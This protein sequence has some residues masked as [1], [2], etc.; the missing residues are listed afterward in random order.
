MK[1]KL[2][3]ASDNYYPRSDGIARFLSEIIPRLKDTYDITIVCPAYKNTVSGVHDGVNV[4]RIPL[5]KF[6]V[7]DFRPA[8]FEKKTIRE[9]VKQADIVF[10]Q[11]IGPVGGLALLAAHRQKK[12]LVSFIHSV[13]WDLVPMAIK[14][15]FLRRVA[16]PIVRRMSR[17]FYSKCDLIIVPSHNILD[18]VSW[19]VGTKPMEVIHLGCDTKKFVPPES[20]REAKKAIGIDPGTL[21]IGYHGRLSREKDLP[22]LL[23]GYIRT[24]RK[25]DKKLLI[26]GDGLPSIKALFKRQDII[27]PGTKFDVVPYLQAMD[28]YVLSSLTETTCLSVLEAMACG[29]PV[30]STRVG[31]VKDYIQEGKNGLFFDFQNNVE[32]AKK[33]D[34]LIENPRIRDD[35]TRKARETVISGFDWNETVKELVK[36]FE[37]IK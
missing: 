23:R 3:I 4:V 27:M 2:L 17:Y 14:S 7:G 9:L 5:R 37:S 26:L 24:K 29:V 35:M 8:V 19:E 32:L 15:L 30:I 25:H 16:Y 28:I 20:K 34:Y 21:V 36:A 18:L 31:F 13:E 10:T 22:T 1:D 33:I 11:T 6:Y 12:R